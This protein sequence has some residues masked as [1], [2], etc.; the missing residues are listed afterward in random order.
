MKKLAIILDCDD[1]LMD[2][3]GFACEIMSEKRGITIRKE[4][5]KDWDMVGF[6][7]PLRNEMLE[8]MRSEEFVLRQKPMPGAVDF[9]QALMDRGH[10]VMLFSA[11]PPNAMGARAEQVLRYFPIKPKNITL[12]G[13]KRYMYGD[14]LLDDNLGNIDGSKCRYPILFR[15]PWNEHD[16][17][18]LSVRDYDEML[19]MVDKIAIAPEPKERKA[20][21][22]GNPGFL[23]VVGP[24]ASGKTAIIQELLKDPRFSLVK[25]LT[26]RIPRGDDLPN[27]YHFVSNEEFDQLVEEGKTLEHT[28]YAGNKYGLCINDVEE[29]WASGRIP[30]KA[31][32]IVGAM[33]VK[34]ALGNRAVTVF[35]RRDREAI[36][37][38]L[39][40]RN[41]KREDIVRRIMTLDAE[42]ANEFRCD[43]TVSNNG[44]L[45]DS[46]SQILRVI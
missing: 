35:I 11:V 16:H 32:D 21:Q 39:L 13:N 7:E 14:I 29:I 2:C 37:N 41:G 42:Y 5:V 44:T 12:G 33:A 34:K 18:F 3:I 26:T 30:V 6:E 31:M 15:Q 45:E 38:A 4:D 43:W 24:S 9:V 25:G 28:E 36:L 1:V 23:A 20:T 40:D 46:V 22:Y 19:A 27:E 10:K 17:R 8:L